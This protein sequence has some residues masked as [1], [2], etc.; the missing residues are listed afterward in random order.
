MIRKYLALSLFAVIALIL[1]AC[2]ADGVPTATTGSP[3]IATATPTTGARSPTAEPD[4]GAVAPIEVEEGGN[5]RILISDD[6][7]AIG[8]F[9]QLIVTIDRIGLQQGGES[10]SWTELSVAEDDREVD[11]VLLQGDNAQEIVRAEVQ[12]GPYGK[13]FVHVDDVTGFLKSAPSTPVSV[14]LPSSKLQIKS[15]FEVQTDSVTSFV[16][17]ITVVAA[18]NERSGIK[19]ILQPVI[20]ESGANQQY[21]EVKPEGKDQEEQEL[22]LQLEGEPQPGETSTLSV[23]D[24]DG[25]P[26]V[27]A[28]IRM[29]AKGEAGMTDA[30]GRLAIDIPQGTTKLR[31]EAHVNDLEGELRVSFEED[32]AIEIEADDEE[33]ALQLEGLVQVGETTTLMVTVPTGVPVVNA[34]IGF[35]VD[36]E[37]GM[38][39]AEGQLAISIP[40]GAYELKVEARLD[41]QEGE[42]KIEF[43]IDGDSTAAE[44][45]SAS[46]G[47]G[48]GE[49]GEL[50]VQLEGG[51]APGG[52]ATVVVTSPGGE[53]AR[54]ATVTVNGEVAGTSDDQGQLSISIPQDAEELEIKARLDE[55]E[56]E[57]EVKF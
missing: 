2:G 57:L 15:P 37:A 33:L 51:P 17:D 29:K 10:G 31:L 19:Y 13:V 4:D 36:L 39:D 14:K 41:D 38:T 27:G 54:S 6:V 40:A 56:G 48:S 23:T 28:T 12:P 25:N 44:A 34:D 32:G 52:T 53:P 16:Y 26:V 5:F 35:K 22:S 55:A 46:Q 45:S 3:T 30:E 47:Q 42:L 21:N 20:T 43:P 8:E 1:A 49:T 24:A 50:T 18:G 11:L 9:A 7:N